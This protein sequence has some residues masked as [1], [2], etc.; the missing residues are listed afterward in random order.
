VRHGKG[1]KYCVVGVPDDARL[2]LDDWLLVSRGTP[3]GPLFPSERGGHLTYAGLSQMLGRLE[4]RSGMGDVHAHRF[5]HTF[6]IGFLRAG[7]DI[8]T[9]SRCGPTH[10]APQGRRPRL[11]RCAP[12][13]CA[14]LEGEAGASAGLSEDGGDVRLDRALLQPQQRCNLGIG[15]PTHHLRE[16][17]LLARTEA[18]EPVRRAGGR[19]AAGGIPSREAPQAAPKADGG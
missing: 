1:D 7:G 18:G 11:G 17:V 4:E 3:A 8:Y 13:G 16:H 12:G 10:P 6:A 15:V 2:A 5:R 9:L 14:H 19:G